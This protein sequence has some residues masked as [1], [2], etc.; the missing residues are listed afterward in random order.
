MG[1]LELEQQ[2]TCSW[3]RVLCDGAVLHDHQAAASQRGGLQRIRSPAGWGA[4][5]A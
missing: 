5:S 3:G 2:G 4:G 1:A